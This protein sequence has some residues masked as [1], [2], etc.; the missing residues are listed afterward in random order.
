MKRSF[1][2]FACQLCVNRKFINHIFFFQSAV[3]DYNYTKQKNHAENANF[4]S[5]HKYP[6]NSSISTQ[7][8]CMTRT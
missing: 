7:A 5:L 1:Y 4:S 6:H 3:A 2:T 8:E